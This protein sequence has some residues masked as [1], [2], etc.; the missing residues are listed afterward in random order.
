MNRLYEWLCCNRLKLNVSK[1]KYMILNRNRLAP[2]IDLIIDDKVLEHVESFKFL[3]VELDRDL[4][5]K[6]HYRTVYEKLSKAVY[7]LKV[8]GHILPSICLILLYFAYFNLI[9]TYCVNAWF[10]LLTKAQQQSLYQLQKRIIRIVFHANYQTHVMP[11]FRKLNTLTINDMVSVENVKLMYRI[12]N[13]MV[14]KPICNLFQTCLKGKHNTRNANILV[15]RHNLSS[16]NKSF[17]CKAVIEWNNLTTEI[18]MS[19]HLVSF[20]KIV[21]KSLISKY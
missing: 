5:F 7:L 20:K 16:I 3:G 9:M 8:F 1:T 15:P 18:K 11:L 14:S 10:P 12:S 6:N 17:L 21:K 4:T 2:N 13:D 19:N